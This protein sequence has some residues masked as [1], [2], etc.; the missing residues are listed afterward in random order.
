M[1]TY[2]H[3]LLSAQS[4]LPQV[5]MLTWNELTAG[6]RL[7]ER[8]RVVGCVLGD[9][10]LLGWCLFIGFVFFFFWV[11]EDT[12]LHCLCCPHAAT[13]I[14]IQR[15][16]NYGEQKTDIHLSCQHLNSLTFSQCWR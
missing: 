16:L 3:W 2:T 9:E 6:R 11:P 7:Q 5:D 10:C 4:Q 12:S 14:S 15:N 8:S 1:M 13:K